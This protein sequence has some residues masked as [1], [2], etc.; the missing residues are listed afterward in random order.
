VVA[1]LDR[2]AV[3]LSVSRSE[4]LEFLVRREGERELSD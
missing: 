1:T 3:S 4:M 2:L